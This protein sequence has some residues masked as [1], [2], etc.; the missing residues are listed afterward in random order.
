MIEPE[1]AFAELE[2]N[3]DLAEDFIKSVICD[4]MERWKDDLEYLRRAFPQ[5][6]ESEAGCRTFGNGPSGKV[7]FRFE[8]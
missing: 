1:V 7:G 4:V 2:E 8:A 3:M 6:R 5:D